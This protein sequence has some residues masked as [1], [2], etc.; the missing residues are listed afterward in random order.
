MT[1]ALAPF[2]PTHPVLIPSAVSRSGPTAVDA[3]PAC[4]VCGAATVRRTARSGPRARIDLWTCMNAPRC[5]G[6][7]DIGGTFTA[8]TQ[9]ADLDAAPLD[10]AP[11]ADVLEGSASPFA[12]DEASLRRI[13][14]WPVEEPASPAATPEPIGAQL[15]LHLLAPARRP[16]PQRASRP[17]LQAADAAAR[18][19]FEALARAPAAV[20][21]L[22]RPAIQHAAA[23]VVDFVLDVA[24]PREAPAFVRGRD[25]AGASAQAEFER[26]RARHRR[27]MRAALP[28]VIGITL[29]GMAMGFALLV[30]RG[31]LV[32]GLGAL[33]VGALGIWAVGRLPGEAL[34]WGRD[35]AAQRR[36]ADSL[37]ELRAA[38]YV[39]LHDRLAPG[40]RTNLDH[41]AIGPAGVLVIETRN[42]RG[43]LTIAGEKV[44]VGERTRTGV[45][46]ETYRGALAVQ[47]ALGDRLNALRS[48][49]RPVLCVHRTIQ[50]LLDN[51][52]QGVR[53]VSGPQLARAVRRLPALL[54]AESVQ[55]LAA[56]AD[57][58]L[59]PAIP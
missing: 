43:K 12:R 42:L 16:V 35:A 27:K 10:A 1:D 9:V 7:M 41:I 19:S 46:D 22:A 25:V 34:A 48:T 18:R 54:D 26:R 32:A 28:A 56:L 33:A 50:L 11:R 57:S 8:L 59:L 44:F 36:T 51:E 6:T 52:V 55:D 58:R 49:V 53:V 23:H 30:G 15:E 14:L 5:R 17:I 40:L 39:V 20:A 24:H 21:D 47:L 3:P 31:F 45:I 13:G 37:D 2:D 4:P 29:I 38:G